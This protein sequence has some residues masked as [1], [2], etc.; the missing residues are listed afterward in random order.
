MLSAT[1][2][3]NQSKT[4]RVRERECE[5]E[6][7]RGREK[8]ENS[9]LKLLNAMSEAAV[10]LCFLIPPAKNIHQGN[11]QQISDGQGLVTT[12]KILIIPYN[13]NLLFKGLM[14]RDPYF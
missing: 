10:C 13:A 14:P 4:N 1:D 3:L 9:S 11:L 5:R 6:R 12:Y 2:V 7:E 8:G